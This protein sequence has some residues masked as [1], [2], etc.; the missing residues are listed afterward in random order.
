M[1]EIAG[2]WEMPVKILQLPEYS[3]DGL[4]RKQRGIFTGSSGT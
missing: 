4:A 1:A 3:T 2:H